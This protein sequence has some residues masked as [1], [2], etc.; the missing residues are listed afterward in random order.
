[1]QQR[2][3]QIEHCR[4]NCPKMAR[5]WNNLYQALTMKLAELNL[6]ET[7]ENKFRPVLHHHL[8]KVSL[9]GCPN[10]C[11][12]PNIKDFGISGY[13]SPQITEVSCSGCM[14]CEKACLEKAI[15]WHS[16][17]IRIDKDL[18]LSCGNCQ[19]VCP[20]GTLVAGESGW[21]L[22]LGGRVGRHPKFAKSVGEVTTDDEVVAWV[23][24]IMTRYIEDGQPGERL[25]HFL[26]R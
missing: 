15:T 19:D 12:H 22:R 20:T 21:T 17:E 16:D 13:V 18:C 3:F 9:A 1:M 23:T 26:E 6:L 24:E 8:P 7:L 2:G 11:S 10:G 14:A 25:T 4:S 5:N